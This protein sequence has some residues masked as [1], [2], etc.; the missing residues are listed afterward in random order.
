MEISPHGFLFCQDLP[1][2]R[3]QQQS[4]TEG[5]SQPPGQYMVVVHPYLGGRQDP[6]REAPS[7]LQSAHPLQPPAETDEQVESLEIR[8]QG[9]AF[10]EA[11]QYSIGLIVVDMYVRMLCRYSFNVQQISNYAITFHI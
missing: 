6:G 2:P 4:A 1:H 9:W 8:R 11:R 5:V 7:P 3:Q 10:R